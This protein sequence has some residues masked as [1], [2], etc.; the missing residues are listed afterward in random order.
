MLPSSIPDNR[1]S[2]KLAPFVR[3]KP[4]LMSAIAIFNNWWGPL[5]G[6]LQAG[7]EKR[8][9]ANQGPA[10]SIQFGRCQ[11]WRWLM[12]SRSLG[13]LA[14]R[15]VVLAVFMIVP[16]AL[17]SCGYGTN[18]CAISASVTPATATADHTVAPP[19][20]EAQFRLSSQVT[21]NCP[22]V[23]DS[24]GVWSTSDP[25]NTSLTAIQAQPG[26]NVTATCLGATSGPVTI[27]NSSTIRGKT[28]APATLTCN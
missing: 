18:T 10:L 4:R 23:P 28:F 2:H 1:R 5:L 21:G 9:L 12:A 24:Q 15:A 7:L 16:L 27:S 26:N 22:L 6:C 17:S 8:G 3:Q 19:G 11:K 13:K 20:N 14:V 25:V